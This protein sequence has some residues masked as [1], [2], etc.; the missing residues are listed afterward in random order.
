MDIVPF[1][2]YFIASV[3]KLK[4]LHLKGNYS[5]YITSIKTTSNI[6]TMSNSQVIVENIIS[7]SDLSTQI[8]VIIV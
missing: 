8:N 5:K 1:C 2:I 4:Y 3:Q 6:P 7:K